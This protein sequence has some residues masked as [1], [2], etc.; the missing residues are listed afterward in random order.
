[1]IL[2]IDVNFGYFSDQMLIKQWMKKLI[3][4]E[5]RRLDELE[6]RR[7]FLY[8]LTRCCEQGELRAPFNSPPPSGRIIHE[9]SLLV[10]FNNLDIILY[11]LQQ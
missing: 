10:C 6:V 7:D 3:T 4:T 1:M 9:R 2:I 5:D 11:Y 8:Y